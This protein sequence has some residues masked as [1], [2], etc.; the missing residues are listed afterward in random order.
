[1]NQYGFEPLHV[2]QMRR[3]AI[4]V[5]KKRCERL[6]IP[7]DWLFPTHSKV[8]KAFRAWV[9]GLEGGAET[10]VTFHSG[11]AYPHR[12]VLYPAKMRL[13]RQ[14]S[15]ENQRKATMKN[16]RSDFSQISSSACIGSRTGSQSGES[17]LALVR[18]AKLS[19]N[20]MFTY[21]MNA[22]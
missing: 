7:V 6:L 5:K 1:M 17:K 11:Y 3:A 13:V 16:C 9:T 8:H 10:R 15:K 22:F 19:V 14:G 12:L 4:G 2:G 18:V 21:R 20:R